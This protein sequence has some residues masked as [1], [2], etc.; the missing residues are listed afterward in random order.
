[1]KSAHK[2]TLCVSAAAGLPPK[3]TKVNYF[4]TLYG[5]I[6]LDQLSSF[7]FPRHAN[8]VKIFTEN[9][10]TSAAFKCLCHVLLCAKKINGR[11]A[12]A[13]KVR[14]SEPRR[15]S[16]Q[17]RR[18]RCSLSARRKC[19]SNVGSRIKSAAA[20]SEIKYRKFEV[21]Q[22]RKKLFCVYLHRNA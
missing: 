2:G 13:Q 1:M 20:H 18:G 7:P 9:R 8:K 10:E 15:S 14:P 4:Y 11:T 21:Q 5:Y 22:S 12:F 6:D 3:D 16:V 17:R 19:Q